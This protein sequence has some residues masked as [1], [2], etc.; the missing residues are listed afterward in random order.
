MGLARRLACYLCYSTIA[1]NRHRQLTHRA[2]GD[3][4]R[5]DADRLGRPGLLHTQTLRREARR[6]AVKC[7]GQSSQCVLVEFPVYRFEFH[8][9]ILWNKDQDIVDRQPAWLA[10]QIFTV[11]Q[12]SSKQSE[13]YSQT[14]PEFDR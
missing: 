5:Y 12:L 1:V 7:I 6:S 2:G 4:Q 8:T 13:S 3:L 9:L 10:G 14:H 11:L